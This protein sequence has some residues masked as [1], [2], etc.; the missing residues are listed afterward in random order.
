[1]GR[2][3]LELGV[4]LDR[5]TCIILYIVQQTAGS[6][7]K[8]AADYCRFFNQLQGACWAQAPAPS[9]RP[10]NCGASWL[11]EIWVIGIWYVLKLNVSRITRLP[12]VVTR[13][14]LVKAQVILQLPFICHFCMWMCLE[15]PGSAILGGSFKSSKK[16]AC[17]Y[18]S[19][20][21]S[22]QSLFVPDHPLL[23]P[24]AMWTSGNMFYLRIQHGTLQD[25]VI[26]VKSAILSPCQCE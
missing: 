15:H 11:P 1:M 18:G 16:L 14:L 25:P 4:R 26:T 17:G 22:V 23:Y 6:V 10:E 2:P 7:S 13:S 21:Q 19:R 9:A 3:K 5:D 8:S 12:F 24:E 20:F